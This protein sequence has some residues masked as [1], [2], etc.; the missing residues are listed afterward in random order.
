MNILYQLNDKLPPLAWVAH[1]Q[2]SSVKVLHGNRVECA[3]S[4]FVA[5]AWN[6][7][8]Q[9]GNFESADWFC[10]T[11]GHLHENKIIFSTPTHVIGGLYLTK[12]SGGGLLHK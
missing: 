9:S 10:G 2:D 12:I 7:D 4:F 5:G 1:C 8:F 11:G 6:G 3:D